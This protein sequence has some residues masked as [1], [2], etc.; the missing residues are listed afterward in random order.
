L[1][2]SPA[3]WAGS[4]ILE[5]SPPIN[6][7]SNNLEKDNFQKLIFYIDKKMIFSIVNSASLMILSLAK[8]G[9]GW[10]IYEKRQSLKYVGRHSCCLSN[11]T[12]G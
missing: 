8:R 2:G 11:H 3:L 6:I 12:T 7:S 1:P 10:R 4:F 9:G 5:V